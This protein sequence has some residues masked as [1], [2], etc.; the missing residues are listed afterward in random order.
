MK[1]E[2]VKVDQ[3]ICIRVDKYLR[4][5]FSSFSR[6]YI[7]GLCKLGYVK[8]NGK[9][10]DASDKVKFGDIIEVSFPERK[11]F[12]LEKEKELDIIFENEKLLVINKPPG[13]LVH[14]ARKFESRKTL[15]D[16]LLER[17]KLSTG[18]SWKLER[19]FLVH[20][21][22]KDTSGV[23]VVAKTPEVQFWLSKQFGEHRVKKVY[24]AIVSGKV[25]NLEGEIFVPLEKRRNIVKVGSLGRES[26][27]KFRVIKQNNAFSYLELYP[28]TGRTHQIRVH[29][30]FINHPIIGDKEYK[31]TLKIKD[32]DV[33]RTMLHA[34][35][36]K[37]LF[38]E[39]KSSEEGLKWLE[40]SAPLPEDFLHTLSQCGL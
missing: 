16:I 28:E 26:R 19:P 18:A 33:P 31:G 8:L 39:E 11:E 30:E 10:V 12:Y 27:T 14:P 25:R 5:R 13:L 29:L 17:Y 37:F 4:E 7:K 32:K 22:D 21:L 20:R 40:F 15:I 36:I 1:T 2:I 3:N 6:E 35:K 34:Y 24:R 9:D 38:P 23:L